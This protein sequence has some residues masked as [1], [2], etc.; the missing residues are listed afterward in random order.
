VVLAGCHTASSPENETGVRALYQSIGIDSSA[1][2]FSD[3]CQTDMDNRLRSEVERSN[4]DCVASSSTSN[5]ERWAEK[6]RLSKFKAGT[7]I[8]I[9]GHQALVYDGPKPEKVLY[10][11]G[12]WL[13]AEVP[14]LTSPLTARK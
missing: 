4:N 10:T 7:R 6:L 8:V 3:I 1:S 5:L 12:H 13:L 14:G 11:S 2:N 9:S